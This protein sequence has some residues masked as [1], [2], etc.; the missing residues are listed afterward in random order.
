MI[1]FGLAEQLAAH[2][3]NAVTGYASYHLYLNP[4]FPAHQKQ[5]FETPRRPHRRWYFELGKAR[6]TEIE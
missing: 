3:S 4:H 6:G 1:Q 2:F 5:H